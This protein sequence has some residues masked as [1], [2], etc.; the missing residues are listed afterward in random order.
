MYLK[1]VI[2]AGG[3]GTR[4]SEE[5][6]VRP[7]PMV[8]I[9]GKPILWHIMKVFESQGFRDFIICTGYMS[10]SIKRYFFE[11]ALLNSD[12][13]VDLAKPSEF[14]ILQS[15]SEDWRVTIVDTGLETM[16]GGRLKRI[17]SLL[18]DGEPFFMTYGDGLSD[19]KLS[20]LLQYH[21]SHGRLATV[22]SVYPP[23]R[24]GAVT[25]DQEGLVTS[26]HEKPHGDGYRV[27]GGFFV[28]NPSVLELIS[29]DDTT[30]ELDPIRNLVSAGQL[31]SYRHDG[32]WQPMDTMRDK[33]LLNELWKSEIAPWKIW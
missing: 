20:N 21:I 19:I 27:N 22:T 12:F 7:K 17:Q 6:R 14:S 23:G 3:L 2:L 4:L 13:T 24:F 33:V 10:E 16:T 18:P 31:R 25:A 29:G 32:F 30:W 11:Y 28:L 1:V 5:T 26:F 9:G 15:K 8:E